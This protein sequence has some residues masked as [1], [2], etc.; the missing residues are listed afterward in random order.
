MLLI[1]TDGLTNLIEGAEIKKIS[2][3][4]GPA[5]CIDKYIDLAN[6]RGGTDNITVITVA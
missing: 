1:C 5:E 3:E 6:S 4:Y 2:N